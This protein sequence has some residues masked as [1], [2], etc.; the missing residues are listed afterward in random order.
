MTNKLKE[1]TQIL[2][3]KSNQAWAEA[4]VELK[5]NGYGV[6]DVVVDSSGHT[7]RI[8]VVSPHLWSYNGHHY[9]PSFQGVKLL[10][11]G[12]FGT[13]QHSIILR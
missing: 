6:G 10:A 4:M 13:H 11:S 8:D 1:V 9:S 3:R 12:D 2:D 7:Y 5:G